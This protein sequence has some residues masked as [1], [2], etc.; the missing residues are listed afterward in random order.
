MRWHWSRNL[1]VPTE[2]ELLEFIGEVGVEM[3]NGEVASEIVVVRV[4]VCMIRK[5]ERDVAPAS[6]LSSLSSTDPIKRAKRC[7]Q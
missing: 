4:R 5:V 2:D 7:N 1:R 3:L 6:S